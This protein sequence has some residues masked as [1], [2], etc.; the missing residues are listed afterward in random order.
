MEGRFADSSL[1][2]IRQ[3]MHGLSLPHLLADGLELPVQFSFR[4]PSS[5]ELL[6]LPNNVAFVH[7]LTPLAYVD[8]FHRRLS[9]CLPNAFSCL[10]FLLYSSRYTV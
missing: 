4:A 1:R 2:P 9:I 10:N 3:S 7:L 6:V 5:A 8:I